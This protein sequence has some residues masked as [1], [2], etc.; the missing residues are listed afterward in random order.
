[1]PQAS[2]CHSSPHGYLWGTGPHA[3]ERSVGFGFV[4]AD[5]DHRVVGDE[6]G[7]PLGFAPKP[8]RH[9]RLGVAPRPTLVGPPT[10]F[11]VAACRD[12]RRESQH[13]N[14]VAIDGAG[15]ARNGDS[16]A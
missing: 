7:S 4:V 16:R 2:S 6:I 10:P 13:G 3:H 9:D 14:G 12:E 15:R 11:A 5:S 8:W 1:M